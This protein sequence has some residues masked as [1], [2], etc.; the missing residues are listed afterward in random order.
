MILTRRA[1][2]QVGTRLGCDGDGGCV[3][4]DAGVLDGGADVAGSLAH[5]LQV[6][7]LCGHHVQR[8]QH[9]VGE[10]ELGGRVEIGAVNVVELNGC[11]HVEH[12]GA[13]SVDAC[14][15]RLGRGGNT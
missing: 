15:T 10:V 12:A 1:I 14:G 2:G 5:C 9:S 4:R 8:Q 6:E 3:V 11:C 7:D 13:I